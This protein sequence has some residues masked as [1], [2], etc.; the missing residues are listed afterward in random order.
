MAPTRTRRRIAARMT[1][2]A[3]PE[4]TPHMM[5]PPNPELVEESKRTGVPEGLLASAGWT[6]RILVI[7]LGVTLLGML[8]K[9]LELAV[10]PLFA[11]L[12][13]R[14]LLNPVHA[15]LRRWGMP[16][17]AAA[18]LTVV[19]AVAV[20]GGVGTYVVNRAAAEY[21]ALVE[22]VNTLVT[23]TQDWLVTGPL[24][25]QRKSVDNVGNQFVGFLQNQQSTILSGVVTAGRTVF[26]AATG[27]VLT[28]FLTI[29]L[30]LDGDRIWEWIT[31]LFS[32]RQRLRVDAVGSSMWATLTGYITGTF[33]VGLFH[34]VVMGA[35]LAILG[36]PLVAPLAVLIFIGGLIP[37]IGIVLFGGLALLVTLVTNGP[38]A[39]VI[40]LVVLVVEN[41]IEGHLLQPLIVGRHVKLHPM[42]IALTLVSASVI[43]GIPGAIFG[44]PIVASINAAARV[45]HGNEE[46]PDPDQP[47]A[48]QDAVDDA[49][50]REVDREDGLDPTRDDEG[51][52]PPPPPSLD[53]VAGRPAT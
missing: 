16:R 4:L 46:T 48:L 15:R 11:A 17:G 14:A 28:F 7:A 33:L 45:L 2:P 6:W 41:Q 53:S 20:L 42:A 5:L 39:A 35:T 10:L 47:E 29:F 30:L 23:R 8:A 22:Q 31:N 37:I 40:V 1:R 21:P 12:L 3:A 52:G 50:D 26:D 19:V 25:L 34:G 24:K 9:K 32:R 13:I 38:T 44:V 51:D 27:I 49:I 36:V 43:A 18:L